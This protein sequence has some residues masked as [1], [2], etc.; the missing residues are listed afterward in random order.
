MPR[1]ANSSQNQ[2]RVDFVRE[3]TNFF[4]DIG[5]DVT[6][7]SSSISEYHPLNSVADRTAPL[8][9]FIQGNDIQYIDF[10]ETKLYLRCK[11]TESDG[12]DLNRVTD[13]AVLTYASVNSLLHS[14][15]DK[16]TISLN[17]MEISPKSSY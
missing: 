6:I 4:Q 7:Q 8:S 15:F 2:Q 10:S 12:K 11:L 17:E 14:M 3:E 16:V 5:Y 1:K 9:F 13:P